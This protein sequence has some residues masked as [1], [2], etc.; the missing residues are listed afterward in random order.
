MHTISRHQ[1]LFGLEAHTCFYR[2]LLEQSPDAILLVDS[3]GVVRYANPS[4]G[5]MVERDFADLTGR[6]LLEIVHPDDVIIAAAAVDEA[7][8][9]YAKPRR[10]EFRCSRAHGE[11]RVLECIC[12]PWQA[13]G[14]VMTAMFVRDISERHA[15]RARYEQV[16][17]LDSAA[18]VSG[19]IASDFSELLLLLGRHADVL[20]ASGASDVRTEARNLRSTLDRGRIIVDQLHSFARIDDLD[21]RIAVDVNEVIAEAAGHFERL[22]RPGV[23]VTHLLGATAARVGMSRVALEQVL[24]ALILHA[25]DT[26]TDGGRLTIATHDGAEI[27]QQEQPPTHSAYL[28]IDVTVS[29]I[30]T[31]LDSRSTIS[32]GDA[33]EDARH[34]LRAATTLVQRAGGGI[35]VPASVGADTTIRIVLPVLPAKTSPN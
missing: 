8:E 33:R 30:R 35:V 17:M 2:S 34:E 21:H 29:G 1:H 13:V 26:M 12:Q 28:V 31:S 27:E 15:E 5:R 10:V 22:V 6:S 11:W 9:L 24:S 20:A 4:W 32:G 23:E 3:A 7:C 19:E 16:Q 14:E 18:Q 25:G